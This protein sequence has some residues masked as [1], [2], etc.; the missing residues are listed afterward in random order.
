M[1][2]A[3]VC[4]HCRE[5]AVTRRLARTSGYASLTRPTVQLSFDAK[6]RFNNKL[7]RPSLAVRFRRSLP[8]RWCN[9]IVHAGCSRSSSPLPG[10]PIR[11]VHADAILASMVPNRGSRYHIGRD[12]TDRAVVIVM[13]VTMTMTMT[14]TMAAVMTPVLRLAMAG[15]V[16]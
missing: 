15:M 7:A 5:R 4:A 3:H 16:P 6:E 2:R 14:V 10:A 9:G 11:D 12:R 13:P 8:E 1:E